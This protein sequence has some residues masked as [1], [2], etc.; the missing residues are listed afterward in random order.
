MRGSIIFG[1]AR[2]VILVFI[3][4]TIELPF[5]FMDGHPQAAFTIL[6]HRGM[7]THPAIT[8]LLYGGVGLG[9]D[10]LFIIVILALLKRVARRMTRL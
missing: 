4:L 10:F 9:V 8:S 3:I 2:L 5:R 6:V 7:E 1:A